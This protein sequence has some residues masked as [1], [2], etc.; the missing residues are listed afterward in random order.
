MA[1][2]YVPFVQYIPT[3]I[4]MDKHL[5]DSEVQTKEEEFTRLI[6][7][8]RQ[9]TN[10]HSNLVS[11]EWEM[12]K[13]L[14]GLLVGPILVALG[15]SD[16]FTEFLKI[17]NE[18]SPS[19]DVPLRCD[20]GGHKDGAHTAG[21]VRPVTQAGNGRLYKRKDFSA[22]AIRQ[23]YRN[24]EAGMLRNYLDSKAE[25]DRRLQLVDLP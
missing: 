7:E 21:R 12:I 5:F 1:H 13:H 4:N 6:E 14:E 10:K 22:A 9:L 18:R 15:M 2:H 8:L 11:V 25:R 16:F 24:F 19:H 17:T 3:L 20:G 23:L